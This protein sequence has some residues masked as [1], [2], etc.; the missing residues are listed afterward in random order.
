MEGSVELM[1]RCLD[2]GY[3]YGDDTDV[4]ERCRAVLSTL[5]K[6]FL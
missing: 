4:K 6:Q 5:Y 1:S 3:F 2:P